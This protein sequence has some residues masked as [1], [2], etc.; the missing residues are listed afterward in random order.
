M[1]DIEP[2]V[3]VIP[4]VATDYGY[5][6]WGWNSEIL[7]GTEVPYKLAFHLASSTVRLPVRMTRYGNDFDAVISQL[8]ESTPGEWADHYLL[9]GQL[10]LVLNESLEA[11]V[12]RFKIR[13]SSEL[14]IEI[15]SDGRR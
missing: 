15:M 5:Q 6:P 8:E 9:R 13:Y 7:D 1:R 2:S 14:G 3:E 11:T 4:I 10:A 12:G